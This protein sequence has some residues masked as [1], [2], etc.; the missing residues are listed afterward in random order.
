MCWPLP[1]PTCCLASY[2]PQSLFSVLV[3]AW[4]DNTRRTLVSLASLPLRTPLLR[5]HVASLRLTSQPLHSKP[6]R[7]YLRMRVVGKHG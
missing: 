7:Q 3:T 1:D 4:A 6:R 2:S 5:M